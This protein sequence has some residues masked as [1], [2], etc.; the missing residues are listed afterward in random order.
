MSRQHHRIKCE[1]QY[2]QAVEQG[3]K[4]FE[5]RKNDRNYKIGDIVYL[6]ETVCGVKTGRVID[7]LE[8][9]YIFYGGKFGLSDDYVIFNW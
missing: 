8:I 2:Y 9:R 3:L 5:I 7:Q 1:T 4:K 6:E